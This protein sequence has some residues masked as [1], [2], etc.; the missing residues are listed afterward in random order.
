M[1]R[2]LDEGERVRNW[3]AD[4]V[5]KFHRSIGTYVNCL[6]DHSFR[7]ERLIEWGPGDAQIAAHPEWSRERD[8]PPFLIMAAD[9][10]DPR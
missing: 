4:G 8:R 6:L 10:I 2:Y 5:I 9:K 1:D 7:L 3:F